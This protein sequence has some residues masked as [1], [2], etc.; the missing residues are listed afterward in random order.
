MDKIGPDRQVFLLCDSW[1]PKECVAGLV[2]E[3]HYLDIICNVRIDIVMYDLP[4]ERT[5]KRGRPK[6]YGERLSPEKSELES[7]K[8]GDWKTGM[9]PV[10]TKLWGERGA[11]PLLR[12][13]KAGMENINLTS[14]NLD[15]R[16]VIKKQA[17]SM[18]KK[19]IK[20]KD[21]VEA[22]GIFKYAVDR[23]L[24][25]YNREG[26]KCLK[27]KTRSRK[28]GEKRQLSPGQE[29]EIQGILIDKHSDQLKL[30]FMLWIR[31]AVCEIIYDKY[32]ITITP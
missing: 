18:L 21:I 31:V 8:T 4:P 7:P 17:V 11:M 15:T 29:K 6:K 19:G 13:R 20:H 27:E 28:L 3:F 32:G 14:E 30:N 23:F 16:E 10:L 25:V 12:S 24:G 9:R 5:G 26:A 22:W 2:N 1:Y